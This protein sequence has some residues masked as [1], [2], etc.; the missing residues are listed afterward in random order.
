MIDQ[1]DDGLG[2]RGDDLKQAGL[3]VPLFTCS[4]AVRFTADFCFVSFAG[5]RAQ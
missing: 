1:V 2:L 5:F 3:R 4:V